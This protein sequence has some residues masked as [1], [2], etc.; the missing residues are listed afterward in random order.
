[1]NGPMCD[2]FSP[3][4]PVMAIATI[5]MIDDDA[6]LR[7][8]VERYLSTFGYCPLMAADGEE[9]LRIAAEHPEIDLIILDV[10]M[11][12]LSGRELA[13]RLT[14]LLPQAPILFCSGHPKQAL[15]RLGIDIKGGQFMQK[16]C[17]P[18]VLKE[19]LREMLAARSEGRW[20]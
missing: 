1:M 17:R 2:K 11:P 20:P 6:P 12:G 14:G 8:L 9:A 5:L 4:K 7:M 18:L 19:H 15:E 10:V 13:E 3:P 16:P